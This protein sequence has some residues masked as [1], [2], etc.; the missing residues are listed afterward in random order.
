MSEANRPQRLEVESTTLEH[1]LD[2]ISVRM[3][4]DLERLERKV[5]EVLQLNG[6]GSDCW[7][8]TK[9]AS[10]ELE[11]SKSTLYRLR[12]NEAL[13]YRKIGRQYQYDVCS[14]FEKNGML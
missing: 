8:N 3:A 6:N 10:E 7:L 1:L 5:D 2:Q 9:E 12:R 14:Y 13:R 4:K 11:V